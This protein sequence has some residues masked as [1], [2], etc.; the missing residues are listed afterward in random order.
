VTPLVRVG[1]DFQ[2][3]GE[4]ERGG[5]SRYFC[6]LAREFRTNEGLKVDAECA[7][8]F[9]GNRHAQETGIGRPV[10]LISPIR[11]RYR[12]RLYKAACLPYRRRL[13]DVDVLHPTYYMHPLDRSRWPQAVVVTV[14]DMI[15]EV[16]PEMFRRSP[17]R[18]KDSHIINADLIIAPTEA[19]KRDVLRIM[20]GSSVAIEVIPHGVGGLFFEPP[21][22][23]QHLT[24]F[25]H[26]VLHVGDRRGYKDFGTLLQAF[27]SVKRDYRRLI[28]AGGGPF[29]PSEQRKILSLGLADRVLW[30]SP[31]DA[32]LR[33]LYHGAAAFVFP[34]RYEGFGL[35][36]LEALASGCSAL[37]ANCSSHPEIG[38]DAAI[39]F[40]PGN[41]TSLASGLL[42]LA[43]ERNLRE[44]LARRGP[45]RARLFTWAKAAAATAEA[46]RSVAGAS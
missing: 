19:T 3:F 20:G 34:S 37:L 28:A 1:Y 36:T 30:V 17:H 26:Y 46:Y 18:Y 41:A 40:E 4:Q 25:G 42:R 21:V 31:E 5:I 43:R 45:E 10:A 44:D 38:G 39:Y 2:I 9:N 8:E 12:R 7:W 33:D 35:P 11:W 23:I 6:E 14:H 16:F 22:G 13:R 32:E 27:S 24:R 15:P 29:T